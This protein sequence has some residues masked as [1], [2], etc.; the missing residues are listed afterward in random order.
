MTQEDLV[1][2]HLKEYGN[3]TSWTAIELYGITRLSAKIY[4]LRA[5]GYPIASV[6]KVVTTRYG[7]KTSICEYVLKGDKDGNN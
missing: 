5:S 1:L 6:N 4:N 7:K 2:N 3:I